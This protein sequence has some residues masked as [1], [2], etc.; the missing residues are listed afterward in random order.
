MVFDLAQFLEGYLDADND[1]A[2]VGVPDRWDTNFV[3]DDTDGDMLTDGW[4][5]Y[6][7]QQAF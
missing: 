4:E 1:T 7:S 2:N 3:D 6:Y 5:A